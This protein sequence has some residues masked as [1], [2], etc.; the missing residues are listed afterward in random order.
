MKI[1]EIIKQ[2]KSLIFSKY[3]LK[4]LGLVILFYLLFIFGSIYYLNFATNHGEKIPVPNL[5]GLSSDEAKKK[6]E[7]LEWEDVEGLSLPTSSTGVMA[8]MKSPKDLNSW[9]NKFKET[10][11]EVTIDRNADLWFNKV[12]IKNL[13]QND[14]IGQMATTDKNPKLD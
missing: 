3:F 8:S 4:H 5:V 9:K 6:I 7:D 14:Y 11:L 10:D 2:I 13:N 12:T 1:P